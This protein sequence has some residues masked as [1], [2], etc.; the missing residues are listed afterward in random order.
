MELF[1]LKD[2]QKE[3][4]RYFSGRFTGLKAA[5]IR[6]NSLRMQGYSDAFIKSWKEGGDLISI[7]ASGSD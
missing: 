4:Y 7:V 5:I 2:K 1:A 6:R 3:L